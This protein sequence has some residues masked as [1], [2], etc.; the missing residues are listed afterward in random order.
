[1]INYTNN[2]QVAV[3]TTMAEKWFIAI[4]DAK[5]GKYPQMTGLGC[6]FSKK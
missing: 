4:E 1:M 2:S 3:D 5:M 6:L